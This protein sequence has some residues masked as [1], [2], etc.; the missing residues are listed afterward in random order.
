MEYVRICKGCGETITVKRKNIQYCHNVKSYICPVCGDTYSAEC[1][2]DRPKTCPKQSCRK[3]YQQAQLAQS[4]RKQFRKCKWCGKEFQ[5]SN[6]SQQYCEGPHYEICKVC[7]CRF[8]ID[9]KKY[10]DTRKTC[11]EKCLSQLRNDTINS[12]SARGALHKSWDD[13]GHPMTRDD[14]KIKYRNTMIERY[15]CEHPTKSDELR[16]RLNSTCNEKYG[17][18]WVTGSAYFREKARETLMDKYNVS[19]PMEISSSADKIKDTCM[20]RYGATSYTQTDEYKERFKEVSLAKYGVD[21]PSMSDTVKKKVAETFN[22]RFEGGHPLRDPAV[23]E[24]VFNTCLERYGSVSYLGS[25]Q[26]KKV[27]RQRMVDKYG[28]PRYSMTG[29]YIKN[30]MKDPS[31]IDEYMKFRE[32]PVEYLESIGGK[33]TIHELSERFGITVSQICDFINTHNLR[34]YVDYYESTMET[35]VVNFMKDVSPDLQIIMHDRTQIHPLELDIYVP[36]FNLAIECNPTATH[37]SSIPDPWGGEP[38]RPSYHQLK[39]D[40]CEQKGI[41]VFH[42]FGHEWE[43]KRPI[44][45]SMLRN[46]LGKNDRK[47]YARNCDIREVSSK[48]SYRFLENNHRQGGVHSRVRLGLYYQDELVSLMTF[49]KVRNTI[50]TGNEELSDCYELLRFCNALNT[51]VVGGASKIFKNFVNRYQPYKIRSFSDRARTRGNLYEKLGFK[52]IRRSSPG[53]MW[54]DPLSELSYSRISTQKHNLKKFLDDENID[55]NKSERQIMIGHGFVQVY[56]S[57]TVNWEWM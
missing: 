20:E 12:D 15:G 16:K 56:D 49:G 38:K 10:S 39:T 33:V 48:D 1:K 19:N 21:N 37:N 47:I 51:T 41:F 4:V 45:Q 40:R 42:V 35:D 18:D 13:H 54:V 8:E 32:N 2:L 34:G 27:S 46:L 25:E 29:E 24:K 9:L 55:L 7:G 3:E 31:K 50:G 43:H 52:E 28:V 44:I 6:P 22:A 57:G 53:Y 11:S 14:V 26:G 5:P 23:R 17:S 30:K 36:E